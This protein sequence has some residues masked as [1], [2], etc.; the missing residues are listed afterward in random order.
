MGI[1]QSEYDFLMSLEKVF[2]D[3]STPI[4]LGPPPIHWTRQINSLTSK[5]IFLI[6]DVFTT[7]STAHEC[8]KE[9][10]KSGAGKIYVVTAAAGANT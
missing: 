6:D 7:G 10:I 8:S 4:E 9:L 3:L 1:T 2:K 5:D